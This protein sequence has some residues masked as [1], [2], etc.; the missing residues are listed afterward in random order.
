MVHGEAT[1]E[2]LRD[3]YADLYSFQDVVS[4]SEMREF[5]A[6]LPLPTLKGDVDEGPI[7]QRE[8]LDAIGKLKLGKA[9]G[10]DGLTAIFYKKFASMIAPLLCSA[11]NAAFQDGSLSLSQHVAILV[12][13]FKK[14]CLLDAGNYRPILLTNVDYKILA[15]VLTAHLKPA[16]DDIILPSQ[17]TYL[18]GRFIGTNIRKIQDSMDFALCNK[19][20]WVI[21]FLDFHKASDSVSYVFLFT[22]LSSMGFPVSYVAWVTLL[23]SQAESIDRNKGW[24]SSHFLLKCSIHQGC[25]LSCHLFNLV[26]QVVILYLQSEGLFVWWTY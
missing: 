24:L 16:L 22:L 3:F 21:L 23:Y 12:L 4:E 20:E 10:T 18:P 8:V 9:P 15:Y 17:T 19:K 26:G 11:F 13:L 7:T 5:I 2:V 6:Q 14:G 1:L 25:P